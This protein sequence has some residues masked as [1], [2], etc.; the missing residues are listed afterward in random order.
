MLDITGKT[1][2]LL[3]G[4]RAKMISGGMPRINAVNASLM[5]ALSSMVY[6]SDG[7][8]ATVRNVVHLA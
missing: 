5:T 8:A 4:I 1:R 6:F 3:S 7:A 2:D